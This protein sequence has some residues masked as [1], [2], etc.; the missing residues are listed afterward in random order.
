MN[1][2]ARLQTRDRLAEIRHRLDDLIARLDTTWVG[3]IAVVVG[4]ERDFAH[5]N[6][7]SPPSEP[8]ELIDGRAAT[9][10]IG[11]GTVG[12]RSVVSPPIGPVTCKSLESG[13]FALLRDPTLQSERPGA[14]ERV[15]HRLVQISC[16]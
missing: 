14:R 5:V 7:A 1:S 11:R 12:P 8:P 15:A 10:E 3:V 2:V 13:R 6:A 4:G 16:S 9:H